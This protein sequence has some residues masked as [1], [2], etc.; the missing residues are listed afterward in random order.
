ML[1]SYQKSSMDGFFSNISKYATDIVK[2]KM[3]SASEEQTPLRVET[4]NLNPDNIEEASAK[5]IGENFLIMIC[6]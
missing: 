3:S 1:I 6:M 4:E 2:M 5:D